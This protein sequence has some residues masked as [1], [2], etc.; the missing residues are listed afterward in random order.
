MLSYTFSTREKVMLAVLGIALV[1]VAWYQLI[2][3]NIQSQVASVESQISATEDQLV[4]YE[5][6]AA[7]LDKMRQIVADYEAQGIEP[8]L[9]PQFD[10]TQN[11]MAYLHSVLAATQSYDISFANPSISDDDGTVHRSGSIKY[12]IGSYEEARRVAENIA[13]GPYP[14]QVDAL[15]IAAK[16]SSKSSETATSYTATMQVTFF[17]NPPADGDVS[18]QEETADGNDLSVLTNWDK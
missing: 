18:T 2:F 10:N 13:R 16:K 4:A 14:C 11:L 3:Q 1:V 6:R 12:T 15:S 5:T 9:L 7:N 8:T 17:E